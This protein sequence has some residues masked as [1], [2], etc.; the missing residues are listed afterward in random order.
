MKLNCTPRFRRWTPLWAR[1][2]L[3]TALLISP[4]SSAV[5]ASH[6]QAVRHADSEQ[7]TTAGAAEHGASA[8]AGERGGPIA[9]PEAPITLTR[10]LHEVPPNYDNPFDVVNAA[11]E[12]N[13][14]PRVLG[15]RLFLPTVMRGGK[16]NATTQWESLTPEFVASE[17]DNA[18]LPAVEAAALQSPGKSVN[19]KL[20]VI[21]ADGKETDYP[22]VIAFLKQIG[23]PFDVLLATTTSLAP[24]MLSDGA[25][26]GYYQ[27]VILIT[28]NLAF[29]NPQTQQWESA[30]SQQEWQWLWQYEAQFGVRQVTSFTYPGGW[31]D[32]YGLTL[33]DYV[34]TTTTPLTAALTSAGKKIYSYLNPNNPITLKG[35]WV[36]RATVKSSAVVTPLLTVG[37]YAIASI[38]N[39]ADGRQNLT[40]T[41]ANAPFLLHS[42]LLS[43][44][45]INWVTKG[46]FL[47]ERHVY[48]DPQVDDIL[49]GTTTWDT[50]ALTDT[51]GAIY[52]MTGDD[53]M[54]A[55]NTQNRLRSTYPLAS[56]L[57][58]EWAFNGEGATGFYS[59]DTLT[60]A[61]Q[62]YQ[63]QFFWVN[64]TFTHQNLDAVSYS[65]AMTELKK[66]H[67]MALT[68]NLANNRRT[69]LVQP[70][71]TGLYNP[72]FQRA[73]KD[74]GIRFLLSNASIPAWNNPS[75]NAGFYSQFEPSIL[76]IPRRAASIFYN[77][78]TPE[79]LVSEYNCY[80]GPNGTCASG[81]WRYWD[82]DLS[83]IEILD[84][85]SDIWLRNL[86]KWDLAPIM[87][88]QTNMRA[89]NGTNS[90]L[91][92]LLAATLAKYTNVYKLPIRSWNQHRIGSRMVERMAYD[93][94]GVS[95][96]LK[97]CESLTLTTVNAANV[98]L[99]GIRYGAT[100]E[101]YGG[102]GISYF[103]LGANQSLTIPL[104]ACS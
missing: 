40:I 38:N 64:H 97:P 62:A 41:A 19:L 30:F 69:S 44:G 7:I 48:I 37:N 14:A 71:I 84:K 79:E 43:Y 18:D 98:P 104:P 63:A 99:T 46:L 11:Q 55:I 2:T 78:S 86:L 32:D 22:A 47:G 91:G 88:H 83:Y 56:S 54:A 31:P 1:L 20:L 85:E 28:G 57:T 103:Q 75:P 35:A 4:A 10:L 42:L 6:D 93:V 80:F 33:V 26:Q 25:N 73:A 76:I 12:N 100:T 92:D 77:V 90:L 67:S 58:L 65:E 16:A 9:F 96:T 68:L 102:Q 36:Y 82:H 50:Q 8:H 53:F 24:E 3:V 23:I 21:A 27:G 95:A 17:A 66:N 61:V 59:P 70:E 101:S 45:T 13:V 15:K 72:E 34:D 29:L 89:Y 60:P 94:S 51:T 49:I 52:R 5:A 74:F 39:Y 87:F 81:R